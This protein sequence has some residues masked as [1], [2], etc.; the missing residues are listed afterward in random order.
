MNV[1]ELKTLVK[2]YFNLADKTTVKRIFAEATL[3]DGTTKIYYEGDL[4]VGTKIYLLDAENNEIPA[5][6]G[7]HTLENGTNVVL[8]TEG[9]VL[10]LTLA[11]P[12]EAGEHDKEEMIRSTGKPIVTP[13]TFD[14]CMDDMGKHKMDMPVMVEDIVKAVVEAVQEEMKKHYD[15]MSAVEAKVETFSA[16]PASEKTLPGSVK[17]ATRP[18]VEPLQKERFE[19]VLKSVKINRN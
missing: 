16:A 13:N 3:A 15:R 10:E 6:E 2:S 7:S 9:E 1:E 19:R 17:K 5:P 18:E 8:G 4:A 12:V 11:Q 14:N